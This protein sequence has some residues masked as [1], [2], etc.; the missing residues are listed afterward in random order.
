MLATIC[1]ELKSRQA[2]YGLMRVSHL[3][4]STAFD[5]KVKHAARNE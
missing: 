1:A 5:L 4:S 2:L 3:I